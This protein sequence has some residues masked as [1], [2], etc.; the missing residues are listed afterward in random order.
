MREFELKPAADLGL[1]LRERV[2]GLAEELRRGLESIG[3]HAIGFGH[4]VPIIVGDS[5]RAVALSNALAEEGLVVPPVRPPTV[6]DG[7]ARLRMTVT[8]RHERHDIDQ[9]ID[10]FRRARGKLG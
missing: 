6:P 2:R 4:V 8:A 3:L 9:A 1:A 5:A 7:T 10:A